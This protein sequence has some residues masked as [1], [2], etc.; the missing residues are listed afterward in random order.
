MKA[1]VEMLIN[2]E[3][4][5]IG[6]IIYGKVL[7]GNHVGRIFFLDPCPCDDHP[8]CTFSI[9]EFSRFEAERRLWRIVPPLEVLAREA[10]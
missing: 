2:V 7:A 9:H 4:Y 5:K 3:D 1:Y 6:D 10:E 8:T